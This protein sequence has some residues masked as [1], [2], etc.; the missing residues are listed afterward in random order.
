MVARALVSHM[1]VALA[2]LVFASVGVGFGS[3]ITV[4]EPKVLPQAVGKLGTV[5][6]FAVGDFCGGKIADYLLSQ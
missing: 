1:S 2:M 3:L 6:G 4:A 5:L